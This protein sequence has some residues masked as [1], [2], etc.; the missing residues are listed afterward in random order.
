MSPAP[1]WLG[2]R[3]REAQ[4]GTPERGRPAVCFRAAQ[5]AGALDT[6]AGAWRGASSLSPGRMPVTRA[7]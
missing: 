5:I 6:V 1:I 2:G 4:E 3:R 7:F